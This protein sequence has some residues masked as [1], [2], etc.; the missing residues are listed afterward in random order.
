MALNVID[1]DEDLE[2][3]LDVDLSALPKPTSKL[4]GYIS[5]IF[6][7]RHFILYKNNDQI[8][9]IDMEVEQKFYTQNFRILRVQKFNQNLM[10]LVHTNIIFPSKFMLF[11]LKITICY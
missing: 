6:T 1:E 2:D 8:V 4:Q 10:K 7:H 9:E 3:D 5:K 11:S